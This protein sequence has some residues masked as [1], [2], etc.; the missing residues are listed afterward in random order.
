MG[1]NNESELATT[2]FEN[3]GSLWY[4]LHS[5]REEI[6]EALNQSSQ[7][8]QAESARKAEHDQSLQAR[9]CVINDAMDR[10]M[11]GIGRE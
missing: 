11:E 4:Q 5:E 6:C 8:R 3:R 1:N 7:E 9:L 10:L 2:T